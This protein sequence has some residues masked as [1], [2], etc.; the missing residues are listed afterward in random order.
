MKRENEKKGAKRRRPP[1]TRMLRYLPHT[2]LRRTHL[3]R[4]A[5]S[6]AH[7]AHSRTLTHAI[8]SVSEY[9]EKTELAA[10][11]EAAVN[12]AVKARPDEPLSF[13]VRRRGDRGWRRGHADRTK[14]TCGARGGGRFAT[15]RLRVGDS[16]GPRVSRLAA[17]PVP[18]SKTRTPGGGP[19]RPRP[20]ALHLGMRNG[21]TSS[22]CADEQ[23]D[24]PLWTPPNPARLGP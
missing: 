12:E 10:K 5:F 11:V 20:P 23:E 18:P 21:M 8:M 17:A 1:H 19:A 7:P 24:A 6:H 14:W 13:L 4:R 16:R 3:P 9:I 15:R 22:R 2:A